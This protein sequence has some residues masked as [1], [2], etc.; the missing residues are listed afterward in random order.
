M[1]FS[2]AGKLGTDRAIC[3]EKAGQRRK[4]FHDP[5]TTVAAIITCGGL[6]PGL[7]NVI[8]SAVY[9]LRYNYGVKKVIGIRYGYAGLNPANNHPLVDLTVSCVE[10][11]NHLG[12]SIL[13]SS[14][15]SQ[16]P[17]VMADTLQKM[18]VNV[19]LCIGGDGTQRG[20]HA[21]GEEL[22]RRGAKVS[23]VGVPKTID[24]D[25]LY[26]ER[27]F[28][29]TTSV[30]AA[31]KALVGAHEEARGAYNG[32]A[33]VKLMGRDAGFIAAGATVAA[34]EINFTLIPEQ[35]FRLE[36]DKGLLSL[37]EKRITDR[38][39]AVLAVAEGAGQDLFDQQKTDQD[40]SGNRKHQD[41]GLFLKEKIEQ[42]FKQKQIPVSLKYID[43]SYTIRSIPCNT[44]DA[45]LS[46]QYGRLAVHAALSGRTD[47]VVCFSRGHYVHV[48]SSLVTSG[49]RHLNINSVLWR[50]TLATTGQP[51]YIG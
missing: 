28:G 45:V 6:C 32:I 2:D 37:L 46:D 24:N 19:L 4:L 41:I 12:G 18:G 23:I 38:H 31:T 34:Q 29:F 20:A 22:L 40:A 49:K 33:L 5:A 7:N 26:C 11:I 39:H 21:L 25:V 44:E 1:A 50:A 42:H 8:R 30:D 13:S 47:M 35:P 48:P 15:G 27:S 16:D 9:E 3:F 43:P 36:G 10:H 17:A 14:R 51:S